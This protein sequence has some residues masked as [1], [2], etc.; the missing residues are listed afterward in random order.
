LLAEGKADEARK[1]FQE[2]LKEL[3]H[4]DGTYHLEKA[5]PDHM[6]AAYFLGLVTEEAYTKY[7]PSNGKFACFP[8]FYIAQRRE[9][10]DKKDSAIEAYERCVELGKVDN[11]HIVQALAEWRLRKLRIP[12]QTG[13]E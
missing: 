9:I 1:A 10:E 6:T 12:T 3:R 2:T 5:D 4:M 11:P 13:Q 8:W 7:F